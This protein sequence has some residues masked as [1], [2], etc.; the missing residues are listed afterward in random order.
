M[1]WIRGH[2]RVNGHQSQYSHWETA[3][4]LRNGK[5]ITQLFKTS[6]LGVLRQN[7]VI[8]PKE[9]ATIDTEAYFQINL[10]CAS[11][12]SSFATC[13][14]WQK[15]ICTQE[16]WKTPPFN[17]NRFLVHFHLRS[18]D[19]KARELRR[20][21]VSNSYQENRNQSH[22]RKR[23]KSRHGLPMTG[24]R[25]EGGKTHFF[26]ASSIAN[27]S[28]QSGSNSE[29]LE[30]SCSANRVPELERRIALT[31][32]G[33]G[34]LVPITCHSRSSSPIHGVYLR[35]W[36]L[37]SSHLLM[38]NKMFAPPCMQIMEGRHA[39]EFFLQYQAEKEV[40]LGSYSF[41][42][43]IG[44]T[45]GFPGQAM[46]IPPLNT[47]LQFEDIYEIPLLDNDL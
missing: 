7:D 9:D 19:K 46:F 47:I 33:Y 14:L 2:Q 15:P 13:F 6:L 36:H 23:V 42:I 41:I 29:P 44:N 39:N 17:V 18:S 28:H 21:F 38:I 32:W 8:D 30:A 24:G 25:H 26:T 11:D 45:V 27:T 37:K 10:T 16:G 3:C 40:L 43:T 1:L 22:L 4:L 35:R 34:Q 12:Y 5:N 31:A 20:A